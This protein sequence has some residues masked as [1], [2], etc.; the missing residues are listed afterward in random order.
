MNYRG[1]G[2]TPLTTPK[3]FDGAGGSDDL[4]AIITH[5]QTYRAHRAKLVLIGWSLGATMILNYLSTSTSS[6]NNVV[7]GIAL[8]PTFD[9]S[10]SIDLCSFQGGGVYSS[11][12]AL[13]LQV[14]LYQNWNV[15]RE[16]VDAR[17]A[18]QPTDLRDLAD[19]LMGRL[20]GCINVGSVNRHSADGL[21]AEAALKLKGK[22]VEINVPTLILGSRDDPITKPHW[23][24]LGEIS[25]N[26]NVVFATTKYGG[27]MGWFEGNLRVST[28]VNRVALEWIDFV[29]QP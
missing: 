18:F 27:H 6:S 15:V 16:V 2:N 11:A 22:I 13:G 20:S 29:L 28:W 8:S 3:A 14:Y 5:I 23:A 1:C 17:A 7:G 19:C 9:I 10:Q 25:R 12:F 21:F 24:P 4:T 26:P